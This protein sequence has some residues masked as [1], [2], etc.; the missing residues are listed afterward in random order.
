MKNSICH[1]SQNSVVLS[2]K[3]WDTMALLLKSTISGRVRDGA[4]VAIT[5]QSAC[6]QNTIVARVEFMD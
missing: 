4:A 2:A 3:D 5:M 1:E 6:A